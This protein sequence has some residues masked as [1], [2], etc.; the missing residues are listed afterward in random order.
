MT[1]GAAAAA[2]DAFE[3]P[4]GDATAPPGVAFSVGAAAEAGAMAA[5]AASEVVES[6]GAG[7]EAEAGG[8]AGATAGAAAGAGAGAQAT[9]E[10]KQH[11][12]PMCRRARRDFWALQSAPL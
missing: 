6:S 12:S 8:A 3:A 4:G 11:N 7:A 1:G 2:I 5:T 9:S 10:G